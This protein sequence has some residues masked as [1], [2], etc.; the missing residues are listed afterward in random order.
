MFYLSINSF[1]NLL[2]VYFC[3]YCN[4]RVHL[5][6]NFPRHI[7]YSWIPRAVFCSWYSPQ[8][9]L[10]AH[11][12]ALIFSLH[13]LRKTNFSRNKSLLHLWV[14]MHKEFISLW[15]RYVKCVTWNPLNSFTP[16]PDECAGHFSVRIS[17]AKQEDWLSF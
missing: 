10:I 1:C 13:T 8:I 15:W 7:Y 9:V 3:F 4:Q 2:T 17:V 6:L 14:R 12:Y 5:L 16:Y 11:I